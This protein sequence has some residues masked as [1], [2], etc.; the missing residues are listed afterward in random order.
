MKDLSKELVKIANMLVNA[1]LDFAMSPDI[2]QPYKLMKLDAEVMRDSAQKMFL[3]NP[4]LTGDHLLNVDEDSPEQEA[5]VDKF[6]NYSKWYEKNLSRRV[7]Y[8]SKRLNSFGD[9]YQNLLGLLPKSRNFKEASGEY[10][11]PIYRKVHLDETLELMLD[12]RDNLIGLRKH[13]NELVSALEN[14]DIN[15]YQ[16]E[17]VRR[18]LEQQVHIAYGKV[19]TVFSDLKYNVS[20]L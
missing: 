4:M 14:L 11:D 10:H 13:T 9:Q 20:S 12:L 7:K 16:D 5:L 8:F 6:N 3:G 1:E 2:N 18:H 17:G 15:D 19:K